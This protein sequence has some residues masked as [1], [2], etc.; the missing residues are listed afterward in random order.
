M[1]KIKLGRLVE[2]L[3]GLI[4]VGVLV[5][6]FIVFTLAPFFNGGNLPCLT[7]FGCGVNLLIIAYLTNL[8]MRIRES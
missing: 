1:K 7:Y 2:L 4:C 8:E 3:I 6:E 5:Y